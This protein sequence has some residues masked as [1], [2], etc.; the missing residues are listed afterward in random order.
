M[1]DERK[2]K[3]PEGATAEFMLGELWS[4]MKD[5]K[6]DFN[7]CLYVGNGKPPVMDRLKQLERLA[8]FFSFI[9]GLYVLGHIQETVDWLKVAVSK[10]LGS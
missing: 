5:L 10:L 2:N 6:E 3:P 7:K 1:A 9:S 8:V 4:D